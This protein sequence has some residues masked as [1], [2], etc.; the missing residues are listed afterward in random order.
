MAKQFR[1]WALLAYA[2]VSLTVL[3]GPAVAQVSKTDAKEWGE[4]SLPM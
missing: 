1:I 2:L 3:I 4:E